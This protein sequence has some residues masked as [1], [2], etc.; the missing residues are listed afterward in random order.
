MRMDLMGYGINSV[1]SSSWEAY[2]A[3]QQTEQTHA[4]NNIRESRY[5]RYTERD[6]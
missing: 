6:Q 1:R 2:R 5:E 4:M 3:A